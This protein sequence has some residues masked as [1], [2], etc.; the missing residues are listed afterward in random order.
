VSFRL[1]T[2]R[3]NVGIANLSLFV[4]EGVGLQLTVVVVICM[5]QIHDVHI[6]PSFMSKRENSTT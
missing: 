3:E 1:T 5:P 2:L 6:S 4:L